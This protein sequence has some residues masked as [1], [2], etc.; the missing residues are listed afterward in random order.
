VPRDTDGLWRVLFRP[1]AYTSGLSYGIFTVR[2]DDVLQSATYKTSIS[3]Q[4]IL[5]DL[6]ILAV[7]RG[8]VVEWGIPGGINN[9]TNTLLTSTSFLTNATVTAVDAGLS[10]IL[11]SVS[12]LRV[13]GL[14]LTNNETISLYESNPAAFVKKCPIRT[15][16]QINCTDTKVALNSYL[17]LVSLVNLQDGVDYTIVAYVNTLGAGAFTSQAS[18]YYLSAQ[19]TAVLRVYQEESLVP[20]KVGHSNVLTGIIAGAAG[21]GTIA[22]IGAYRLLKKNKPPITGFFGEETW[23][24][25]AVMENPLYEGNEMGNFNNPLY[26]SGHEA[27][28]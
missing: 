5:A 18:L 6:R 21:A 17:S 25:D 9:H 12:L 23:Q 14:K 13:D 24:Q 22:A 7:P 4:P 2:A 28:A 20:S 10:A 16:A 8:P 15:H 19:D 11:L 1:K 27:R 26:E 3:S